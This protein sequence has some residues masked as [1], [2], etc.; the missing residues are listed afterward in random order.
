MKREGDYIPALRYR[1]LTRFYDPIVRAT[2]RESAFKRELV[3]QAH[4]QH[5][6]RILDLGCGTGTLAIMI[7]DSCPGAEVVGI[8]GDAEVLAIARTKVA[9]TGGTVQFDPGVATQLP[10]GLASFD[11]VLSSLLFHHLHRAEKMIALREAFRVLKPGGELHIADWGRPDGVLMRVAFL[12]LQILDG[13][14]T[15]SDSVDGVLPGLMREAG[16][17]D[18]AITTRYKTVFGPLSLYR[19]TKS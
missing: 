19:G 15:T 8:D 9:L 1:W 4:L 18:V 13:F 11:R 16:L 3:E 17:A 5:E 10:Y 7:K 2:T 6:H 14:A 12:P